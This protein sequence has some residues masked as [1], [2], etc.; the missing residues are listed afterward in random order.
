[1]MV[2]GNIQGETRVMTTAI[3]LE[4]RRGNFSTALA[5]GLILLL[6]AFVV[7]LMLTQLQQRERTMRLPW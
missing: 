6:F 7:N 2:G 3:V 5:L 4:T 1:M